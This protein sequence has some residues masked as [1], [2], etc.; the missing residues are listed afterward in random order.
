LKNM[1]S[2]NNSTG[3]EIDLNY[4]GVGNDELVEEEVDK[5]DT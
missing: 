3:N 5:L 2:S 4:Y 1:L